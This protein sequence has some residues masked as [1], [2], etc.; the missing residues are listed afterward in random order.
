VRTID[1]DGAEIAYE[2][3]GV[4][5][6]TLAFAHG[7]CSHRGHW[8]AQADAFAVDHRVLRWDRRGMGDSTT[9]TPADSP[10]RHADDLAAICDHEGIERVVIAGHAGGGPTALSF[11]AFHP[12]RTDGL[13]MVDTTVHSP[14]GGPA[15][16]G[17]A[18]GVRRSI[19]RLGGD[20]EQGDAYM[21]RIYANFFG[22]LAP[23]EVRDAA[24]ANAVATD[25]AVAIAEMEHMIG[26]TTAL[27][28]QVRCPVLWVSARPDDTGRALAAFAD[29]DV[30]VGHVVGSGHFVQVE[31]PDQVNA[32]LRT[33]VDHLTPPSG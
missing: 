20:A 5:D 22:P 31:V 32:M 28:S 30:Q 14:T 13:V 15:D 8:L 21:A 29:T 25:R 16:E 6:H 9:A 23:D 17:F 19:E 1:V 7:W 24:V 12:D 33:F 3:Q 18:N 11:A 2:L 10:R 26:D 4:G 27:A